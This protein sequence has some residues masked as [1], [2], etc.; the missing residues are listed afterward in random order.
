MLQSF[1]L[2][3]TW[4]HIILITTRASFQGE[5]DIFIVVATNTVMALWNQSHTDIENRYL[6]YLI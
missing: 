5:I 1:I 6:L 4:W 2:D 3:P